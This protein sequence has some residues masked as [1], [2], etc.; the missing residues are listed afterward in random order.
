ML[1]TDIRGAALMTLASIHHVVDNLE[2]LVDGQ[3]LVYLLNILQ[4]S[5]QLSRHVSLPNRD[6][7]DSM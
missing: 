7:C 1:I 3:S 6:M 5:R 2:D 4:E